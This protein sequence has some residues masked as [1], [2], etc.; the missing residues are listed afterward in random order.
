[1]TEAGYSMSE[2]AKNKL[3]LDQPTMI[4]M[5][6]K[7]NLTDRRII[8]ELIGEKIKESD[9]FEDEQFK[10]AAWIRARGSWAKGYGSSSKSTSGLISK[11]FDG[12]GSSS[13]SHDSEEGLDKR[14]SLLRP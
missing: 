1:L 6:K 14:K 11:V 13:D 5:L 10:K 9:D 3:E 7:D 8:Y 2:K 12:S 4:K